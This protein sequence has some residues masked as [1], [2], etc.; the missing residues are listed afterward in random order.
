MKDKINST[1]KKEIE[2][3][4]E[5]KPYEETFETVYENGCLKLTRWKSAKYR[6]SFKD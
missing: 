1:K 3:E 5:I 2:E 6:I 4:K